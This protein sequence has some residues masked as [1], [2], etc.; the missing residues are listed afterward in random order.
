[1]HWSDK[2]IYTLVILVAAFIISVSG[3]SV[4]KSVMASGEVDYCYITNN[5]YDGI[6]LTK[7]NGFR[8]WR[9]DSV[10]GM[11]TTDEAAIKMAADL[12]CRLGVRK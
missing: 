7:L 8:N 6:R 4:V 3:Y 11:Y 1:M 5:S 2:V 10:I 9:S 12:N